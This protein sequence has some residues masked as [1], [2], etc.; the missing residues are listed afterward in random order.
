MLTLSSGSSAL[1]I[2]AGL[3]YGLLW[4]VT[5]ILSGGL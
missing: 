4:A 2:A 5:T 1:L 3:L